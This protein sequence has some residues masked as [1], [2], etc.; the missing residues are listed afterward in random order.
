MPRILTPLRGGGEYR[1]VNRRWLRPRA[2]GAGR[3][4]MTRPAVGPV[5][6]AEG[7]PSRVMPWMKTLLA[8][9]RTCG[10]SRKRRPQQGHLV[11]APSIVSYIRLCPVLS[12]RCHDRIAVM[13][14]FK[15]QG[16]HFAWKPLF[17]HKPTVG[18]FVF[19]LRTRTTA[20]HRRL[21]RPTP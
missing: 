3:E 1:G 16:K 4:L 17:N 7:L 13:Q 14:C 20:F 2:A 15:T 21:R 10:D 5:A 12:V 19:P 11:A 6:G 18:R 8:V 9:G